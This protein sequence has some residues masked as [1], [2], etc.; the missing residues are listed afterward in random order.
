MNHLYLGLTQQDLDLGSDITFP[1]GGEECTTFLGKWT[2]DYNRAH[3][4]RYDN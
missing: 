2:K 4:V 3:V 1:R